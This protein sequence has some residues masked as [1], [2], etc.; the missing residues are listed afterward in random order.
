MSEQICRPWCVQS[1]GEKS[2]CLCV[3]MWQ[4]VCKWGCEREKT[5]KN[6][7]EFILPSNLLFIFHF[8]LLG[9]ASCCLFLLL[10][11][12]VSSASC[13][14]HHYSC[15]QIYV[16][17][18]NQQLTKFLL[19][20]SLAQILHLILNPQ[21]CIPDVAWYACLYVCEY[22]THAAHEGQSTPVWVD[23]DSRVNTCYLAFEMRAY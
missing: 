9:S 20:K 6:G 21:R 12:S 10:P 8:F 11:L 7:T 16:S 19:P 2:L 3:G 14:N 22:V 15:V 13:S 1:K 23:I 5:S 4:K 17:L 18:R